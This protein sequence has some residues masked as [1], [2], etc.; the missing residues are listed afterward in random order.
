[1]PTPVRLRFPPSAE[2]SLPRD[3]E[4]LL[5]AASKALRIPVSEI[6]EL[7]IQK[8]S[9][10]ARPRARRWEVRA[11]VYR[12]GEEV[13]DGPATEPARLTTAAPSSRRRCGSRHARNKPHLRQCGRTDADD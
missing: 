4:L 1:M 10:D 5:T 2:P 3:R 8:V 12:S 13:P 7:R 9:F 11:E 6:A